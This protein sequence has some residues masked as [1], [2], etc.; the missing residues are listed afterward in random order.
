MS[1]NEIRI[2]CHTPARSC[3]HAVYATRFRST[4]DTESL[5]ACSGRIRNAI[6]V[7][8]LQSRVSASMWTSR[9]AGSLVGAGYSTNSTRSFASAESRST[10]SLTSRLAVRVPTRS[11]CS[12]ESRSRS[13]PLHSGGSRPS[14]LTVASS[15]L[16]S[17]SDLG[18]RRQRTKQRLDCAPRSSP[19]AW[20][21]DANLH[22]RKPKGNSR[23]APRA[24]RR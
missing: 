15:F 19:S 16:G 9:P 21:R 14:G 23:D 13:S 18:L 5:I 1:R 7:A 8:A 10:R 20:A 12:R 4:N 2:D 11:S 3:V 24:S 6:A 17:P 22:R